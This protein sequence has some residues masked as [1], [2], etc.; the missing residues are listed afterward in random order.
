MLRDQSFDIKA[1][2]AAYSA[3]TKPEDVIDEAYRRIDA[4]G[5]PG[6]FL[7]LMARASALGDVARLGP[8]DPKAKPLWGVPF[9]IKDNIDAAGAPTTAAC[10]AYEYTAECDA[11]V[12]DVLRRAGAILIGK[13]N[14]DQFATGLVGVR[15]PFPAPKNAIDPTIV[16]GGSSCGSAVALARGIVGFALGTDTAGSGRVPAAFNNV[17]GLKPSLGALSNSGVVPACRSLDAVSIFALTVDDAYAVFR[18][19]AVFDPADSYARPIPSPPLAPPPSTFRV[20]VPDQLTREFFGDDLQAAAFAATLEELSKIGGE[21][22]ELDFTPF[23]DVAKMLY[24][25]AWVAERY[26]VIEEMI[27]DRP[28]E[29]HP[30][31]REVIQSA[32]DLAAVDVF[33]GFY[34]LQELKRQTT[35]LLDRI[36]FLC[37]PSTP[38]IYR[39]T[40]V[41]A[42]PIGANSR[43]GVYT[44]FANLLDLCALALPQHF[45]ADGLP[46]SVTLLAPAARDASIAAIGRVLHHRAGVRAGA[47]AWPLPE[48]TPLP[49]DPMPDEF[50]IAVVGAHMTGLP[51]NG[52]LTR[53]GGRFLRETKT[54]PCYRLYRLPGGEPV[55]PGLVRDHAGSAIALEI[56]AL[57]KSQVGCF[58]AG[59]PSPL[60]IGTVALDDGESVAGFLC[61]QIGT[62]NAD[63]VSHFG[64]WR[65]F[66]KSHSP[67]Q[68]D[69]K[70]TNHATT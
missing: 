5:D 44:N 48:I 1:L 45:R 10:P 54:A 55:R 25:G 2:H 19:A 60:C 42:D 63:E 47:T 14:L 67:L 3:G 38:T 29:I 9:A 16:P 61:E 31:T 66:L 49:A 28:E 59:I 62:E 7:Y 4:A 21:I 65:A 37:V 8:F 18:A 6:V 34:R 35:A 39:V 33:R 26:T 46:G 27:L 64:G 69:S 51:L 53:L 24:D 41:D 23:Y 17:V 15:T 36:D 68:R 56:W 22:I 30:I 32:A 20:G 70:E 13:T 52:Q 50:A 11:F 58:V 40:D 12:V 43:L 57:P